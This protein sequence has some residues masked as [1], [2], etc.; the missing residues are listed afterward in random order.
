MWWFWVASSPLPFSQAEKSTDLAASEGAKDV[1][2][3]GPESG[4]QPDLFEETFKEL[5]KWVDAKS[6]KHGTL[7]LIR[8]RRSGRLGTALKVLFLFIVW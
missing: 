7:L 6:S 4:V 1:D 2:I 3:S 8:E 5:K